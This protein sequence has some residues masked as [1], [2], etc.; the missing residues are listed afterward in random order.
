MGMKEIIKLFSEHGTFVQP[1]VLEYISKKKNPKDFTV[2]IIKGLKEYPLVLT[3]D[4]VKSIEELVSI[5]KEA[6]KEENH[7]DIEIE[8][9]ST[10]TEEEMEETTEEKDDNLPISKPIGISSNWKPL[11]KEYDPEIKILKDVTGKSLCEGNIDDFVKLFRDRYETIKRMFQSQRRGINNYIPLNKINKGYLKEVHL[12]GIV[13]DTRTTSKGHRLIEIEDEE[14]SA[15]LLVLKDNRQLMKQTD[16]V[17]LD[18]VISVTGTISRNGSL[19]VLKSI[20]FPD[21]NIN[22][23]KNHAEESLYV[24][25][26]ADPHIGSRMFMKEE[27]NTMIR[28]LNG[29]IGNSRQRE[30]AGKIKYIVMPGDIVDGIG[31]YP[32]QEKELLIKDIYK[33]YEIIAEQL[34]RIPDHISIILQPGNHDAV[35]P[36]EPQP[37]FEKEI[38]DLFSGRDITFIGNPCYFSLHGIDILSYHGQSLLDYATSI[39]SLRYNE[40]GEIMKVMLRKRHLAPVY[41]GY[42]PIAPEHVDYMIID[43]IPDIFATGHVHLSY[44]GEY[45]GVTLINAS[46]WQAQ[47]SYQKMLNFVPDPAKLPIVNLKT[48]NATTMD[49]KIGEL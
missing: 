49:F 20:A 38:R 47:T 14:G 1:E 11:A 30:V 21:I 43:K 4:D 37:A 39:P 33:Q 10:E 3:L 42:T 12:V 9:Y 7:A 35:R 40:P 13:K 48:G 28:W 15:T 18:E 44:I 46:S 6:T 32:N 36:A 17:L 41:G 24:A 25:F 31:I 45:R 2:S 29:N 8:Q 26:L 34:Q 19:I 5:D 22:H 23:K 27:W 16:E